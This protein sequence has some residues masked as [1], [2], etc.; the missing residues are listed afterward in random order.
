VSQCVGISI[1]L[2]DED[3]VFRQALAENL[4]FDGHE[5]LEFP[6]AADALP[7]IRSAPCSALVTEYL[8]PGANGV[9]LADEFRAA[10]AGPTVVVTGHATGT[11]EGH[12]ALRHYVRLLAK[13]IEYDHLHDLLHQMIESTDES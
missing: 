10:R 3:W 5:V 6:T 4:R 1:L 12:V 13:P 9:W 2:V 8:V 7:A 11:V